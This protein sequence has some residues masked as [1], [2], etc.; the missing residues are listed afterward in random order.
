MKMD[1]LNEKASLQGRLECLKYLHE[2]GS[3]DVVLMFSKHVIQFKVYR[4]N[5]I[6]KSSF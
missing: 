6:I 4:T 3:W 1:V 5:L 2:N